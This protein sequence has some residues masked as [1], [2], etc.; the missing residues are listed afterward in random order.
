M[1]PTIGV[2]TTNT[3]SL[4]RGYLSFF[5]CVETWGALADDL[6]IVDGGTTD[7]TYDQLNRFLHKGKYRIIRD[8]STSWFDEEFHAGQWGIN[9][10]IGLESMSTDWVIIVPGDHI[11]DT[12][13]V[14]NVYKELNDKSSE[15]ILRFAR[16]RIFY[17]QIMEDFK[18]YAINLKKCKNDGVNLGWGFVI[19]NKLLPDD[20]IVITAQSNFYDSI[21]LKEKIFFAGNIC[22]I[23]GQLNSIRCWSMGFYFFT[24]EQAH[25]HILNFYINFNF[26]FFGRS[27]PMS[28]H[29]VYSEG[30][31][32]EFNYKWRTMS[33]F[34]IVTKSI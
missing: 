5:A 8:D 27:V 3:N 22:I 13:N 34:P 11:L 17:G 26:R 15:L 7:D 28:R 33:N 21:T 29:L 23:E 9:N 12:V 10:K 30:L 19:K 18:F 1:R 16:K 32:Q 31:D 20:P 2:V 24:K 14:E 6:V 25:T 4:S